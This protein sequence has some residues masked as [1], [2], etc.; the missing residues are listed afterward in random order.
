MTALKEVT[1]DYRRYWDCQEVTGFHGSKVVWDESSEERVIKFVVLNNTNEGIS[2]E[3]KINAGICGHPQGGEGHVVRNC[4]RTIFPSREQ[5]EFLG[6]VDAS[7]ICSSTN[8][9][10][11]TL[12]TIAGLGR[13]AEA[14][15]RLCRGVAQR[16][17]KFSSR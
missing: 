17:A 4:A 6:R 10:A 3:V 11:A 8:W 14:G 2:V 1:I 16:R 15:T 5:D 7:S 9:R 12:F 13:P